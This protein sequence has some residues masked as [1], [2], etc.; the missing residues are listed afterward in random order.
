MDKYNY[1]EVFVVPF[2][3]TLYIDNGYTNESDKD[4]WS[5]FDAV[6]KYILRTDAENNK[7]VQQII[8]YILIKNQFGEF[9]VA[10]RLSNSTEDRLHNQISLGFGG[11]INKEDGYKE[12]LFKCAFRELFEELNLN[13]YPSPL[14]HIGYV[15]D[16]NSKTSEHL[17]IVFI[18]DCLKKDVSIKEN[19]NLEGH[20]MSKNELIDKYGK[21]ESWAK[22]IVDYMVDNNL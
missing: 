3:E 18:M 16:L 9:Y 12:P 8:P 14:K 1:E 7:E 15:R 19:D 21:L 4:I 2:N 11:H 20:W 22:F 5:K 10:K 13:M 17:G 6:G